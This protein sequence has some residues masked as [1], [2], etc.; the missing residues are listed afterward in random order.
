MSVPVIAIDGPGGS[1]KGTVAK[2]IAEHFRFHY[3]DSGA[4]YRLA[5]LVVIKNRIF[6]EDN[7]SI[8]QA[9]HDADFSF[10]YE[11]ND[12]DG[13]DKLKEKPKTNRET[14]SYYCLRL[15]G[16]DVTQ[17][18]RQESCS[19]IAS[20]LAQR[21]RVRDFF[22]DFQRSYRQAPGLV[23]EGRD[24]GTVIFPNADIKIYLHADVTKRAERR[25]LQLKQLGKGSDT[26]ES[27]LVDMKRRD[28][29][30]AGREHAPL[31][32]AEDAIVLDNSDFTVEQTFT[33]VLNAI[34][35]HT[36]IAS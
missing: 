10:V 28:E 20:V 17:T 34:K 27:L 23:A 31:T 19:Q 30:D 7:D 33:Q 1:G 3:L 14:S 4:L 6:L 15:N 36:S 18:I 32:K 9:L 2:K 24:I 25:L 22:L 16:E 13:K 12:M 8:L 21:V 26:L 35:T 5:A 11:E 29:Q